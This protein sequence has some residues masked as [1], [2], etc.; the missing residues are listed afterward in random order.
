MSAVL[1]PSPGATAE[2]Y[3]LS[4]DRTASWAGVSGREWVWLAAMTLVIISL[5]LVP[6]TVARIFGPDDRVHV[7]TYWYH[8]D[9][10]VYRAA[11]EEAARTPSWLIHDHMTT[12]PHGPI[13][14]F[15]LY[16]L[17]GKISAFTGLPLLAVYAGAELLARCALAVVLYLFVAGLVAQPPGRRLAFVLAV[18]S[19]GLGF[20][21]ALYHALTA[22]DA[23]TSGRM[24]N[25]YV[26]ATTLGTFLTA[27]HITLG[28]AAILGGL[29]AFALACR[30]SLLGL[31]LMVACVLIVGLVHP[32]NMP[33]LL[34]VFGV[35]VVV[36]T[37]AD[38]RIPPP[39]VR[40]VAMAGVL[41]TPIVVYN[42]VS[43]T[44][45]P[46]WSETF[47]SQNLLP[48]PL[49]WELLL[50][51]GAVLALTPLGI[52]ALRGR[53]T[54]EQGVVLTWLAVIA[55]C[56]YAPV[57]YQRRFAFG[58]QPALAALAALGWPLARLGLAAGLARLGLP[59]ASCAGIA[60]RTLG[61]SLI[62]LAFTT[63][64][65]AY[66]VVISSAIGGAPLAYYVVDRDT[67]AL[68]EWIAAHSGPDDVVFGS[69]ETGAVL[70]GILPG[71]VYAGHVGVTIRPAEKRA[72]IASFYRGD[73]SRDEARMLLDANRVTYVVFGPEERKLGTWDPGVELSLPIAARV[74]DAVAYRTGVVG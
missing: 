38:R 3:R 30:G 44:F 15:P 73:L 70:G 13:M 7:G 64:V 71:H 55:L 22:P 51:Y 34:L 35:Y 49:P 33:V 66:F 8:E 69:F 67:Y 36:R 29:L 50:D 56:M 58:V 48:S 39:A 60:R 41:G 52:L 57:P 31:G 10:P 45:A 32:F 1:A 17:I 40:A 6:P 4:G 14:M 9:F 59:A 61:Y 24:I 63:V 43:F 16:V 20:W 54:T 27:P 26:E 47:G 12:E 5:T 53:T 46:V 11:M 68:S 21:T 18:F 72:A 74:G 62:M 19:A 37:L 65:A 28:L 42:Y 2:R 25:L 23:A